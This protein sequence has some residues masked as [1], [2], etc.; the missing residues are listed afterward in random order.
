MSDLGE[1]ASDEPTD[2]ES[3][4]GRLARAGDAPEPGH[5]ATGDSAVSAG[6]ET[7]LDT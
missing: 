5:P 7:S 2:E 6:E 1:N 4:G 3:V